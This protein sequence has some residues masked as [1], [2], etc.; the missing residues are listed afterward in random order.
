MSHEMEKLSRH[1][2]EQVEHYEERMA[3][4]MR[5]GNA[6][7]VERVHHEFQAVVG[8]DV[9]DFAEMIGELIRG[10]L[11]AMFSQ[12]MEYEVGPKEPG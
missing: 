2:K 4:A 12:T 5:D 9:A 10:A 3:A 11:L 8:R 1:I 6:R 7:T